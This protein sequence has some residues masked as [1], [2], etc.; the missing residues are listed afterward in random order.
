MV[1]FRWTTPIFLFAAV[2]SLLNWTPPAQSQEISA[3]YN[4]NTGQ[5]EAFLDARDVPAQVAVSEAILEVRCKN[6]SGQRLDIDLLFHNKAL[7]AGY[8]TKTLRLTPDCSRFVGFRSYRISLAMGKAD[9]GSTAGQ[10]RRKKPRGNPQVLVVG[11]TFKKPTYRGRRVDWCKRWAKD[12]GGPA[13]TAFCR[14]Q[15]FG[16]AAAWAIDEN[17]G[18]TNPTIV[19]ADNAVC[20]QQFC[21][22]FRFITCR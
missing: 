1:E 4:S 12:C 11:N 6:A 14:R 18:A 7:L 13:A 2:G 17:I 3:R 20:N 16:L 10:I 8:Y 9:G 5:I 21:D 15:G 19:I 22:G